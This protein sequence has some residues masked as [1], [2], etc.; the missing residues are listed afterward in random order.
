MLNGIK[1]SMMRPINT[2]AVIILGL[3]TT[4]WGAWVAVPFWDVFDS[5][6]VYSAMAGIAPEWFWGMLAVVAG[7]VI[8]WGVIRNSYNSLITGSWIGFIQWLVVAGL[9]FIGHWQNPDGLT[10]LAFSLY[11]AY[12]HLNLKV[13]R[14][15]VLASTE[16]DED[17]DSR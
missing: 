11:S 5:A 12:V 9:F 16:E 2:S 7:I 1:A 17:D 8:T 15:T 6:Q 10:L 13:N 4:L 14:E 3:F